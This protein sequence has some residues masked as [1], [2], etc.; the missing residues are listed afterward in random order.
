M[1]LGKIRL[2]DSIRELNKSQNTCQF[3]KYYNTKLNTCM[4]FDWESVSLSNMEPSM[5]HVLSNCFHMSTCF[6]YLAILSF[7]LDLVDS[8]SRKYSC[9]KC[10][11]W[12]SA[13]LKFGVLSRGANMWISSF[14]SW[15]NN[16]V[17]WLRL[18]SLFLIKTRF[19][20]FFEIVYF[21]QTKIEWC[22]LLWVLYSSDRRLF[23]D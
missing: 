3:F 21:I 9:S 17:D 23:F 16:S 13:S 18:N 14:F 22:C 8:T 6:S 4:P 10:S 11:N 7:K 15:L 1:K 5:R 20:F 12:P 19:F 2:I